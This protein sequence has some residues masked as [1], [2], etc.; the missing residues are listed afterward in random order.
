MGSTS[1]TEIGF[2]ENVTLSKDVCQS[3]ELHNLHT[4]LHHPASVTIAHSLVPAFSQSNPSCFNDLLYPSPFY[5]ER[6]RIG[7]YK[8]ELD[9]DWAKKQNVIYWAGPNTGGQSNSDNWRE[10]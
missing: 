1:L 10:F 5:F 2:L 7:D 8:G 3:F 4:E 6:R 9:V